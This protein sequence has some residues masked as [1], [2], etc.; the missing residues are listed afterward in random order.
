MDYLHISVDFRYHLH[1]CKD[2][3]VKSLGKLPCKWNDIS[4][5][6]EIPNRFEFTSGLMETCSNID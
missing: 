5:R 3:V 4:K 6:F 1:M 2:A